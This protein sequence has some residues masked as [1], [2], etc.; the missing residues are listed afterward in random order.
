MW[1]CKIFCIFYF[2]RWATTSTNHSRF[3]PTELHSCSRRNWPAVVGLNS[4]THAPF[5]FALTWRFDSVQ[6]TMISPYRHKHYAKLPPRSHLTLTY[7]TDGVQSQSYSPNKKRIVTTKKW[8]KNKC[9]ILNCSIDLAR[10]LECHTNKHNTG[11]YI[12]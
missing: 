3:V 2:S 4:V 8:R 10:S 5:Q 6:R 12:K 7:K 1:T 9:D 11:H